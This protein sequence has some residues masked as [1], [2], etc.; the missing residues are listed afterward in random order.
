[1]VL[2]AGMK[3]YLFLRLDKKAILAFRI[4]HGTPMNWF[5]AKFLCYK[6]KLTKGS[7]THIL[8]VS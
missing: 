5:K 1:M 8:K 3:E 2:S 7:K 4:D 6:I